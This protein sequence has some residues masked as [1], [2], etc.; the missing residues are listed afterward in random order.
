MV[1]TTPQNEQESGDMSPDE[2]QSIF[3]SMSATQQ[4]AVYTIIGEILDDEES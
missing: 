4:Q 2:A 3:E 1:D